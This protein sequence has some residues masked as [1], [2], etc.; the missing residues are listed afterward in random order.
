MKR[1]RA[2]LLLVSLSIAFS[3]PA[4]SQ[5]ENRSIGENGREARQAARQQQKATRKLARKQRKAA[6]KYQ[7][8]QRKAAKPQRHR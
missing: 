8:A 7:K 3:V 1:I 4:V 6:R 5:R 2:L